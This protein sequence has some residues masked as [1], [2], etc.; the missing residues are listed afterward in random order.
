MYETW[1]NPKH[2]EG[3]NEEAAGMRTPPGQRSGT[4]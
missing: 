2:Y 3:N 1:K 4:A